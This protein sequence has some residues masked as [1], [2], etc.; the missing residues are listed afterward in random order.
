MFD[1]LTD[2]LIRTDIREPARMTLSLPEVYQT[3]IADDVIAFPALRAHQRHAWHAFLAQLGAIAVY[4]R[5][6]DG[7]PRGADQWHD[8]LAA[9]TPD[10]LNHSPWHLIVDDPTVPAFMQCPAPDGLASYRKKVVAADD[11]DL[12]VTAKNHDIKSSVAVGGEV[13]D[14]IF[15][16]VSVQTMSGFG[17]AGNYGIA[18][19]NGGYSSRPCL[20][21][22]PANGGPGAHLEHDIRRLVE[23][24]GRL[25]QSHEDYFDADSGLAL[26][27]TEPW[28]GTSSLQLDELHP[29]FIEICRRVRLF[30]RNGR[31]IARAAA[32]KKARIAAKHARGNVGDHWTPVARADVKALSISTVG[33]RY[34]R[35]AELVLDDTKYQR[36][37]A[38]EVDAAGDRSWR[39]VARGIAAGQGKTEGYH[40][41]S[42]IV[43]RPKVASSL[44]GVGA[45]RNRL[46]ELST[47]Q[48]AEIRAVAQALRF[49]IAIA[50]TGGSDASAVTGSDR[51]KAYPYLRQFDATVDLH[52]FTALQERF[53]AAEGDRRTVEREFVGLLVSRAKSLLW[54]AIETVPCASIQRYR[55]RTRAVTAFW[56]SLG[57]SNV[58]DHAILDNTH[59]EQ[60]HVN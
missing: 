48:L 30:R 2:Q 18:R 23:H 27:W 44:M 9:L 45:A 21:L 6:C 36:P 35:L 57:R 24:R 34:D 31:I 52:F 47:E 11:L 38:M 54:E 29:H 58:I 8:L 51:E 56:G 1:L 55:A 32:S 17:G 40:E 53:E 13:D 20:G 59:G 22:A 39:L 10:S 28:D 43:L 5:G 14:W 37:P 4:N 49:A 16:L 60:K 19:M 42:D 7:P 26:L 12:L 3:M 25:L 33:F 41:R 15:S 50:A 46:A